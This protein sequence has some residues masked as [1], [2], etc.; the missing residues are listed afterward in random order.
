MP[1]ILHG[2]AAALNSTPG[3]ANKRLCCWW[4]APP[5]RSHSVVVGSDP[6]RTTNG[7]RGAAMWLFTESADAGRRT[8]LHRRPRSH[9]DAWRAMVILLIIIA[10]Y[11]IHTLHAQE[12]IDD[13]AP[14]RWTPWYRT[15]TTLPHTASVDELQTIP[16]FS[17]CTTVQC[18]RATLA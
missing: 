17:S 14:S 12:W 15:L 3:W 10:L 18:L 4:S 7:A 13:D 1:L 9:H 16:G 11:D 6:H 8:V 2:D 5:D